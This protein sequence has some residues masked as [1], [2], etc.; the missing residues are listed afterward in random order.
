MGYS[1]DMCGVNQNKFLENIDSLL[2]FFNSFMKQSGGGSTSCWLPYKPYK[3]TL[4]A[5]TKKWKKTLA[6]TVSG[7]SWV[8]N[9]ITSVGG[10]QSVNLLN[11]DPKRN[12]TVIESIE[13]SF[14]YFTNLLTNWHEQ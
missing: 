10:R 11:I 12:I 7:F 4:S 2:G 13:K 8:G 1:F 6:G 3:Q 5:L 9:T 14:W